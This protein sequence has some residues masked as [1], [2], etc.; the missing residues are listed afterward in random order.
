M[1]EKRA[2]SEPNTEEVIA[3]ARKVTENLDWL[4]QESMK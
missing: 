4:R 3:N 2:F 1:P